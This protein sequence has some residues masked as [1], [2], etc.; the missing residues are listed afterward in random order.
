MIVAEENG[1]S[2]SYN[3]LI[4][5]IGGFWFL[6]SSPKRG[7]EDF[8]FIPVHIFSRLWLN[9]DTLRI[10][11]L[12]GDWLGDMIDQNKLSITHV[13]RDREVILTATTEELRSLVLRFVQ[14]PGAFPDPN[15]MIRKK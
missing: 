11:S 3:A 15:V 1:E 5:Q 2:V 6:D 13:R 14:D 7:G 8:H 4:G 10:A 9:G 12:E